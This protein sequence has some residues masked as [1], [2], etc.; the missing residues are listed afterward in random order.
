M[1]PITRAEFLV[2]R[3]CCHPWDKRPGFDLMDVKCPDYKPSGATGP[4]SDSPDNRHLGL[5]QGT[6][7][8]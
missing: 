7:E 2:T 8:Q 4:W 3:N 5:S 6:N 1:K